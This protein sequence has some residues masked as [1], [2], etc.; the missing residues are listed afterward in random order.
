MLPACACLS[1]QGSVHVRLS[2]SHLELLL[3]HTLM[4]PNEQNLYAV[5]KKTS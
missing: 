1:F 2:H 3:L 5:L 4:C